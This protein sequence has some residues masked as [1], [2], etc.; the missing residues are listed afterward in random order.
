MKKEVG[1]RCE[2]PESC[3]AV[4]RFLLSFGEQA[5]FG[6]AEGKVPQWEN[7]LDKEGREAYFRDL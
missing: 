7:V 3:P 4:V 5:G 1:E 2:C 6:V